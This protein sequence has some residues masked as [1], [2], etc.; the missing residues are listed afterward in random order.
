MKLAAAKS[1]GSFT[2]APNLEPLSRRADLDWLRLL[3][4]GALLL[5]HCALPFSS[6]EWYIKDPAQSRLIDVC[7]LY[8]REFRLPL[9]FFVSGAGLALALN[10][11]SVPGLYISRVGRLL[12]PLVFGLFTIIPF[13]AFFEL[14]AAGT[15][16]TRF[17]QFWKI[18]MGSGFEPAGHI[19]LRHLWFLAYLLLLSVLLIPAIK[20]LQIISING[21]L[22][23]FASGIRP[24]HVLFLAPVPWVVSEV[25]FRRV[26]FDGSLTQN[27]AGFFQY[28]LFILAGAFV[29][30]SP[31]LSDLLVSIRR[32]ALALGLLS[33]T[34]YA[35][36]FLH[37]KH[38][39]LPKPD[40]QRVVGAFGA[41]NA[42]M[43]VVFWLG[44]ARQHL[45]SAPAWL[46]TANRLVFP[47]YVLHQPVIVAVAFYCVQW[48]LPIA[49]KYAILVLFS[50]GITI[51]I[52][53]MVDRV[54]VLRKLLGIWH[55][56]KEAPKHFNL[57]LPINQE[58]VIP[59]RRPNASPPAPQINRL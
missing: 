45:S 6:F 3:A 26:S 29:A 28:G 5:F 52:A 4:L 15:P 36:L 21:S 20:W 30:L 27:P 23:R 51:A 58:L 44:T 22:G 47:C 42:L 17:L 33:F 14:R 35:L 57:P 8:L 32:Y 39:G 53:L 59:A 34:G 2:A 55:S 43:W 31:Q 56:P 18:Y 38:M 25:F 37:F 49:S 40:A 13:Q 9:L 12:I 19:G 46:R 50:G 11:L 48:H 1:P 10:R 7:A 16:A 41:Y 54:P 24:W